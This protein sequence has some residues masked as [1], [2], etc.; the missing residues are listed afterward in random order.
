MTIKVVGL[1]HANIR[2][3]R[4]DQAESFYGR[5]LGLE[6]DPALEFDPASPSF[7]WNLGTSGIQF[8]TPCGR[9]PGINHLALLVED[10]LE[11]K[12]TLDA[13]GITYIESVNDARGIQLRTMDPAGNQ[14]DLLEVRRD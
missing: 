10:I 5:I 3:Q 6:R 12:R 14:I 2:L 7:W 9:D 13:A 8:H 1:H 11:A 4:P